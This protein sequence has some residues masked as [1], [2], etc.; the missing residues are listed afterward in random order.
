MMSLGIRYYSDLRD[1]WNCRLWY[2]DDDI[3]FYVWVKKY[4]YDI[5]I[6]I[7]INTFENLLQSEPILVN[8]NFR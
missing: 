7:L 6:Y 1:F 2:E 5:Y 8:R 4:I 3:F